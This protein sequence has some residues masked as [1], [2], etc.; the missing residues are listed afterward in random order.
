M[1][2][3]KRLSTNFYGLCIIIIISGKIHLYD[4]FISLKKFRLFLDN[5][6]FV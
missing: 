3:T 4:K 6:R 2:N 5:I 1:I